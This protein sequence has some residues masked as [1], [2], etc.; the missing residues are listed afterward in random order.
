MPSRPIKLKNNIE[1]SISRY[2]SK[3][4]CEEIL[5]GAHGNLAWVT[6]GWVGLISECDNLFGALFWG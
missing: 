1:C 3:E 5:L 2:L 4:I 6:F